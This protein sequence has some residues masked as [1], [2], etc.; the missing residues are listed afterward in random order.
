MNQSNYSS[1]WKRL[2]AGFIDLIVLIPCLIIFFIVLL[3]VLFIL[4][5]IF[6]GG[7]GTGLLGIGLLVWILFFLLL[8]PFSSGIMAFLESSSSQ[9]TY[10]K[11]LLRIKVVNINGE[12]MSFK[13]AFLRNII[14]L[15]F[16]LGLISYFFTKNKQALHDLAVQSFVVIS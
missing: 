5:L 9:A 14:K 3:F 4:F 12:R 7:Q 16:P 13:K 1:I 2:I 11:R 8:L 10:G 6:Y 15:V